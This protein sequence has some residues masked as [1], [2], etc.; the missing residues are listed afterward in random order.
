M[1]PGIITIVGL[2][3]GGLQEASGVALEALRV[4]STRLFAR[5][6]SHPAVTDL[7]AERA[8]ETGDDL[9]ASLDTFEE[10][11]QA[12]AERVVSA[13]AET[14][15]VFAVPGSPLV[16]EF[17][18]PRI[19]ALAAEVGITVRTI[20]GVS[21]IDAM[22]EEFGVDPLVAGLQILDGRDLPDPLIIA[23]PTII[24]QVDL[25]V[26]LADVGARLSETLPEDALVTVV[27]DAG[28]P[29]VFRWSG[30][31]DEIDSTWA[32]LRTSLFVDTEPGGI[33]GAISVM[34]QLRL[35][36]PWDQEQ[37]HHSLVP[38]LIEETF[39]LA[40]AISM[41]PPVEGS[42]EISGAYGEV[43]E[44]LG[45]V[46]LQILFHTTIGEETGALHI[47]QVAETLR[48][49]LVRR[50]PHV[51]GDSEALDAQEV[52][53]VWEQ[54]KADEKQS[55][56]SVLDGV[57]SGMPA[58]ERAMQLSR[59][60]AR[61][62]FE[63]DNVSAVMA[64]VQE[65]IVELQEAATPDEQLDEF[66]DVLLALVNLARHL[67]LSPE[68]ALRRASDK[69]ERRFREVESQGPLTGVTPGELD[70]RWQLA[71]DAV[72]SRSTKHE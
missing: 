50:H 28:T 34:R 46:L 47:D 36:C 70:K 68:V 51:F 72:R 37:T 23:Q 32:G 33:V 7:M 44:E 19:K 71:K 57:P 42:G 58:T 3:P 24:A 18:V 2:G 48:R 65:E 67:D 56:D 62:G 41:L 22:C 59:R 11:Y 45:D 35:A 39:E 25:P 29:H 15:V 55:R 30:H 61:L 9:Y 49:K 5:T 40:E 17:T 64:K 63:W 60:A 54:V 27:A 20:A 31:P 69:F 53:A 8:V 52:R 4:P 10:V 13:A 43:E 26:V 1:A 38:H 16:G 12:L 21:F 66:G 6:A 14:D